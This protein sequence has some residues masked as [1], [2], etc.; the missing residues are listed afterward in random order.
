MKRFLVNLHHVTSEAQFQKWLATYAS[1]IP[2]GAHV[3]PV[4]SLT[5]DAHYVDANDPGARIITFR[6]F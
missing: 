3:M 2:I 4:V 6:P 1:A 5:N